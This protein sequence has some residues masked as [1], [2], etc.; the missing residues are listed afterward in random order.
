MVKGAGGGGKH[1][2][3]AQSAAIVAQRGNQDAA[4]AQATA[5]G[6]V[7]A[8]IAFGVVAEHDFA[9]ANGFGGDSGIGLQANSEVG[10]GAAGAGAADDFVAGAE[11]DGGSGCARKVLS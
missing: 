7:D 6:Q 11:G 4:D 9:G 10:R 5:T 2:K 8:G 1:L 3:H